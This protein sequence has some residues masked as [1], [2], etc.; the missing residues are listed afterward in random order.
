MSG[1][2][3][4]F[5]YSETRTGH[6][7]TMKVVVVDVSARREPLTA[8][9]LD[10]M[11]GYRLERMPILRRRVIPVPYGIGNPVIV[12]DP[13][14]DL[15]RHL[16]RVTAAPP[17]GR[18]QLDEAVAAVAGTAL[19]R[20]RPLWELTVIDGLQDDRIAFAMKL[21]HALA[22]G[23]ASVAM[24]D[25]AFVA[26][27]DHA[28]MEDYQPSALPTRREIYRSSASSA[29]RAIRFMPRVAKGTVSGTRRAVA[30]KRSATA[31]LPSPF[32]GPR[33]PFNVAL[34]AD[35]T[36]AS[37]AMP[38]DRL[39]ALKRATG[40][41][42]NATFLALC[43]G[44]IRRY[45]ERLGSLP[46]STLLASVPMATRTDIHRLGGNH[47]DNLF[48]PIRNDIA[49]P[50]ERT[51]AVHESSVAARAIREEFGPHLFEWRSGLVPAGFHG[52]LPRVWGATGLADRF[53]PPIN[54]IASCVRGP[55]DRLEVDGGA[56]TSLFSSGP[57]LE[58]V[59]LNITAWSYIDN[60]CVSVLGCSAS[61]PDPW[62]LTADIEA[63]SE[64]WDVLV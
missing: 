28:V 6:M 46:D 25:N 13:D 11:I 5:L 2:D 33:T 56:V 61:L 30:A 49:D 62:S 20:D 34:T 58:G 16:R 8:D 41:T 64:S 50:L 36:F 60:M 21:H 15:S 48:L 18:H 14:F 23:V 42:L 40:V 17:G 35:R 47:V 45:L 10:A 63:E 59:G 7:H 38:L 3:A 26:D 54:L 12:D 37:L 4:R 9:L 24:L 55:S 31:A 43:G 51:L 29:A 1:L 22:D 52:I 32:A 27:E 57:I 39:F 19:P 53:R 44:A